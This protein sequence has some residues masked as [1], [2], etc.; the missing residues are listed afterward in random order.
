MR[1]LLNEMVCVL[2]FCIGN[3]MRECEIKL[4]TEVGEV[5]LDFTKKQ[6]ADLLWLLTSNL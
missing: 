3:C 1:G 2:L 5:I 4:R 6:I